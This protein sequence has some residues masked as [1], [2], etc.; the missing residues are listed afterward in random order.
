MLFLHNVMGIV[1]VQTFV[2]SYT[3]FASAVGG[4]R[5]TP[6][7]FLH[8]FEMHGTEFKFIDT[9]SGENVARAKDRITP[10]LKSTTP[11]ISIVRDANNSCI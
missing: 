3:H 9:I 8:F 7:R 5:P 1:D 10:A 11:N 6:E 4:T 2:Y